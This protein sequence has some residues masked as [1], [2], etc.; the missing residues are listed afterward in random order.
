MSIRLSTPL[1][2]SVLAAGSVGCGASSE[3]SPDVRREAARL[4]TALEDDPAE[5]PLAEVELL[6]DRELWGR[7]RTVLV[8]E[9]L[10]AARRQGRR[11][12][13]LRFETGPVRAAHVRARRA[14]RDRAR[15]LLAYRDVLAELGR[16][17]DA[18]YRAL[19]ELTDA[20]RL[21]LRTV[22]ELIALRGEPASPPAT[23]G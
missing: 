10:P 13:A 4:L 1:L 8:G 16:D 7:A 21:L 17:D 11:V 15:A 18:F 6:V 23:G 2:I 5:A 14:Y 22:D 9:A 19:E 12:E 20:Q 3:P